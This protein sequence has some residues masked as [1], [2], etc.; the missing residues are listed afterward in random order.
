MDFGPIRS[1]AT[2]RTMVRWSIAPGGAIPS[3]CSTCCAPSGSACPRRG[4]AWLFAAT[5]AVYV[6]T[7]GLLGF[8]VTTAVLFV[9]MSIL[10]LVALLASFLSAELAREAGVA[11]EARG[12]TE[13]VAG[14]I[15]RFLSRL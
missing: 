8:H 6:V 10:A 3:P 11:A 7:I 12:E 13:H 9:R 15:E 2:P 4:Q 1:R 5:V 14:S